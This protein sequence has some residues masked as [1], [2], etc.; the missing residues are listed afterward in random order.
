MIILKTIEKLLK[1]YN[2]NILIKIIFIRIIIKN[3][4]DLKIKNIKCKS[5][6]IKIFIIKIN[7]R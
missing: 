2:F 3:K 4:F 1:L 5:I 7:I 6:L